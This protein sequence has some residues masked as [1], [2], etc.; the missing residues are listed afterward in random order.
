VRHRGNPHTLLPAL[1]REAELALLREFVETDGGAAA[2]AIEGP[3]G[4]GKTTLWRAAIEHADAH[5][6]RVLS[7]RVR[8]AEQKLAY[9]GLDTLCGGLFDELSGELPA[10]QRV[11]L[12]TALLRAEP[13]PRGVLARAVAT[14]TLSLLR[15]AAARAPLLLA[16]DDVQWLDQPSRGALAFAFHRL[17]DEDVRLLLASRDGGGVRELELDESRLARVE[18]GPLGVETLRALARERTGETLSIPAGRRLAELS[19]GNPFYALELVGR[20]LPAAGPVDSIPLERLVGDRIA[21]LPA[22]TRSDLGAVAALARPSIELATALT[23]GGSLDPAFAAGVLV[24]E[25]GAIG[26]AHPLLAS[27]AYRALGPVERRD[28]HRRAAELAADPEERAHHLAAATVAPD[29]G[30]AAAI[31]AGAHAAARRGAPSTAAQLYEAAARL[32]PGDAPHDAAGRQLEAARQLFTAGDSRRAIEICRRLA[33]ELRPG[34]LRADVLAAMAWPGTVRLDEA[35]RLCAQAVT[36]ATTPECRARSLLLYANV[37]M[38][39]SMGRALELSREALETL[40]DEGDPALR[41]WA[42]GSLGGYEMFVN[43][44]GD[45]IR[46]LREAAALEVSVDSA[47][48]GLDLSPTRTLGLAL[49]LR[50]EVDEG[51]ELLE[52]QRQLACAT[53][54]EAGMAS[55][56]MHMTMLECR[57]GRLERARE[58]ADSAVRAT[59]EGMDA[60]TLGGTLFARAL[61][62]AYEGDEQ[63]A[64]E[65]AARGIATGEA[66]GDRVFPVQNRGVLGLLELSLGRPEAAVEHLAGLPELRRRHAINEPGGATF[67]PDC[68]E[69]LTA[70]GRLEEATAE[71]EIWERTGREL[72]RPRLLATAGR[73][74]G[75]LAA[76][77]GDLDA[78]LAS[79]E[80]ALAEH[81]RFECPHE[82]ARTRL[83][84]AAVL[85]RAGRRRDARA[86]L[87]DALAT[88]EALGE[89]LWADR[90]RAEARRLGGR[91][92]SDGSLTAS[93]ERVAEL[94]AQGR[95][96]REVAGSLFITV[97]TVEANLTR[98]YAKLGVRSRAELAAR[99]QSPD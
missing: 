63:L 62:A 15:V 69:A 33:T 26:F 46:M 9:A 27:A 88:F 79:F 59:D 32:T 75:L 20:D 80:D 23:G 6:R 61:V 87:D 71:L 8:H 41:A 44:N 90:A 43:P 92:P 5:G 18:V 76:A 86:Q 64:R 66:I 58:L 98:I 56:A 31:D 95:S 16:V 96:N 24:E 51:R 47:A 67:V 36:E 3:A 91:A 53:G 78:A 34:D 85:R 10:P 70:T 48:P 55:I 89:P 7:A 13:G 72:D 97:R 54:D 74:R 17:D 4:I 40:G 84:Y 60:A 83:A 35:T 14:G 30:V 82:L 19:G 1:G 45:G 99:W 65:L 21:R 57:A 52:Q 73:C 81:E 22:R 2:L 25:Q 50:D 39:S 11:A 68:I 42:L 28:V 93:E 37:A 29:A 94:V 77:E 49:F 12:E 38:T